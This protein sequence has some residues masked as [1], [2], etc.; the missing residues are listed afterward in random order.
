MW[1]AHCRP[2]LHGAPQIRSVRR[3]PT[4]SA[5]HRSAGSPSV[6]ARALG[7]G[8][9][10]RHPAYSSVSSSESEHLLDRQQLAP[11]ADCRSI[12]LA[13]CSG[14]QALKWT[15]RTGTVLLHMLVVGCLRRKVQRVASRLVTTQAAAHDSSLI[16]HSLVK[17][18]PAAAVNAEQDVARRRWLALVLCRHKYDAAVQRV[19]FSDACGGGHMGLR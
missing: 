14:A 3:L 2:S 7:S 15:T 9:A 13:H 5:P 1:N 8:N 4:R 16:L 18:T 11:A 10:A 12:L 17:P 19:Q 6:S